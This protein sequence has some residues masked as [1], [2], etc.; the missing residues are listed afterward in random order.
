LQARDT[1]IMNRLSKRLVLDHEQ[2]KQILT[3]SQDGLREV[4][5]IHQRTRP[6]IMTVL[7]KNRGLMKKLLRPD[8][9][10]GY[11]RIDERT[12][13]GTTGCKSDDNGEKG[14]A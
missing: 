12:V 11:E 8:Q 1:T 10:R 4:A 14:L 9:L 3:I 7:E 6:E 2:R 5:G 13:P